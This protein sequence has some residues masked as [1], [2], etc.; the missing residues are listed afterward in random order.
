MGYGQLISLTDSD[1]KIPIEQFRLYVMLVALIIVLPSVGKPQDGKKLRRTSKVMESRMSQPARLHILQR[2]LPKLADSALAIKNLE[3]RVETLAR[4]ADLSWSHDAV[5]AR[6]LFQKSYDQLRSIEPADDRA[7]DIT[8]RLPRSKLIRLYVRFF[9]Q[10]AKHDPAWKEQLL[11]S[12]PEFLST[13]GLARNLDL[14]TANLLLEE[15]DSKA[16]D[17]MESG[18]SHPTSGLAQMM[19]V[20]GLLMKFRQLDAKKGDQLFLQTMR[21][22][23]SQNVTAADDLLTIGNYLFTGSPP[24]NTPEENA[25]ISPVYVGTVA[26]HADISYDRPGISPEIVDRYLRSSTSILTRQPESE[27]MALQ[28]RA[29]A[30]LLVPKSRRFA[31]DLVPILSNLSN[32]IDPKRTNSVEARGISPEPSGPQTVQSV[33]ETLGT[34]KD[35]VKRDEYCLRMIWSFYLSTDFKSA[36]TLTDQMSSTEIR[37][38]LSNQI[39]VGQAID[40][41]QKGDLNSARLQTQ[42]LATSKERSFLWFAIAARL[43]E[44]SDMQS[45]RIAIDSGLADARRTD[46][47]TKASLLLLGSELTSLIDFPAGS[48]VL[49]E[50]LNIINNLDSDLNDP[51]RFDRFVRVKAGSQSAIFSTDISGFKSGSV[52]GAFKVPVSKDPDGVLSLVLQL[53]NEYVRSLALVAFV[54]ELSS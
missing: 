23:E 1:V 45:G 11:K 13:P 3:L 16:F 41:L 43:I 9:S 32:G 50:A 36:A 52:A 38:Q 5:G 37:Q 30:F 14:N 4:L 6:Q 42:K 31:P 44:K 34:I 51:L 19:Q 47:S 20:L 22:L 17:F 35:P 48:N 33:V 49:T 15:K 2:E 10:V 29:A 40:T 21:Q 28:Y 8:S 25:I 39:A 53:K 7:S 27:A 12:A 54:S 18:F 46:G 26:F 24:S